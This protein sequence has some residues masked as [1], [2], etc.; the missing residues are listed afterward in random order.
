[1]LFAGYFFRLEMLWKWFDTIR[2]VFAG[3]R[4]LQKLWEEGAVLFCVETCWMDGWMDGM[5]DEVVGW[6]GGLEP[7]ILLEDAA[8]LWTPV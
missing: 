7:V 3:M 5:V 2:F 4:E 6:G 1:M 8:A